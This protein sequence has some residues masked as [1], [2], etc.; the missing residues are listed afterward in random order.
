MDAS[1]NDGL[2]AGAPSILN[3]PPV[4]LVDTTTAYLVR[5]RMQQAVTARE[6]N[7]E[8]SLSE[9]AAMM[10]PPISK[11]AMN[12]RLKRLVQMAKEEVQ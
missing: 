11:P 12:N 3:V 6:T 10:V 7:P 4:A 2:H 8:A 1:A 5:V 9:L